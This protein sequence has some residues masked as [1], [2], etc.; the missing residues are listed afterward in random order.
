MW[1]AGSIWHLGA[2][3]NLWV[4][5]RRELGAYFMSPVAYLV[6]AAFLVMM[7]FFFYADV[8]FTIRS[9]SEPA[10][11]YVFGVMT[12]ILL[13]V[14]P[15]LTMRLLAEEQRLG[16]LELLLTAPVRDWE[17]V[18]GKY[19]A[20]LMFYLGLLAATGVY[21]LLLFWMG[22][23]PDLGPILSGYLGMFMFG[24]A[25]LS[26]GLFSSSLSQNQV[27]AAVLG[28]GLVILLAVISLLAD[29]IT[30]PT[31]Q[32]I[33]N[34]LDLR[35]HLTNFRRGLIDTSDVVYYLSVIATF[36]FLTVQILNSRRWR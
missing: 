19:L 31:L 1:K 24:A 23:N 34:Q 4:I 3:R 17:V 5:A 15:V 36:L 9:R 32:Q 11:R 16:T 14:A 10:L 2:M 29:G 8:I 30:N 20:A 7:G 13:F 6:G 18:L 21:P 25:L 26:M 28:I 22:G 33:L 27:V 35:N 12:T